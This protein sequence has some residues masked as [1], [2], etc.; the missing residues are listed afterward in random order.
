MRKWNE[1]VSHLP[2]PYYILY[3]CSLMANH[4]SCFGMMHH[5]IAHGAQDRTSESPHTT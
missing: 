3:T 2:P 5:I 1:K 4:D